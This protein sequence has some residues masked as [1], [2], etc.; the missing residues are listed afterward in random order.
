MALQQFLGRFYL[1]DDAKDLSIG[2]TAIQL[3]T[4]YYYTAGYATEAT[5]QLC[6]HLQATIRAIGATQDASTVLY[7][8]TTG[9]V[10]ITLETAATLTFT[11]SALATILGFT[12]SSYASNTTFTAE[13][14]PRY[15]WRPTRS[16]WDYPNNLSAPTF[17]NERPQSIVGRTDDGTTWSVGKTALYDG[18]VVYRCLT[19]AEV[20]TPTTGTVYADLR[21]FFHDV[22]SE[23]PQPIR[24]YPDRTVNTSTDYLTF[25]WAAPEDDKVNDWASYAKRHAREY[26][27]LWDV[28]IPMMKAV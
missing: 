23:S 17:W 12:S 11:D 24:F 20:K 25:M 9:L 15:V 6:E 13:R 14:Q 1:G 2:A 3:T 21:Q 10:T 7:S 18:Y 4:G 8:G 16:A 22:V 28:E 19:A 27:T 5:A 26:L